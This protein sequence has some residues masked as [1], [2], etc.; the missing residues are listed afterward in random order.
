[1]DEQGLY[2]HHNFY[3]LISDVWDLR[4]LG[5]LLLSDV[6]EAFVEAYCVRMRGGTLRLQ[7]QYLRTIRLPHADKI[8]TETA[9]ELRLAFAHRDR[10]RASA[11]ARVAYGLESEQELAS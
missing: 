2:P 8:C 3:W 10:A 11:A 9:H 7:A 5:G 1:M 6:A 4:V